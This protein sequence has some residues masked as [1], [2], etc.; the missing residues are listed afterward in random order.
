MHYAGCLHYSYAKGKLRSTIYSL[1][2]GP[3]DIRKRLAQAYHG[4]FTLKKED[5]PEKLQSDWEWIQKELTK[6]G[7]ILREDE[8]VFKGSVEHTCSKIK[9]KTGVK[10]AQKLLDI[11]LD[12]ENI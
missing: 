6:F 5:F 12:L 8:S 3:E 1:A 11:Y 9:N 4:F 2:I 7:P 10:I